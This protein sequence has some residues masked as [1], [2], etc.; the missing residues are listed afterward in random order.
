MWLCLAVFT[1]HGQQYYT[2]QYRV[3]HG[4]PSDII[5]GCIQDSLGYFWIATDE[6]I[7]KY[8]GLRFTAYRDATPAT[9][10]RAS[11]IPAAGGSSL[12]ATST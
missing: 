11:S 8:D 9:T 4:L 3:A 10:P 2:K 7:V 5:K 6:G 1:T 12:T